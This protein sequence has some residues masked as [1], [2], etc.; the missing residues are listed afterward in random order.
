M[1]LRPFNSI[2][3]Y[4]VGNDPQVNVIY[5]NGD[6]SAV[7]LNVSALSNLG[8]IGNIT[9]TGGS[10][11]QAIVT[12]GNGVLSFSTIESESNRAAPMPY[13]IPTGESY[14]VNENFQGLYSYPITIDGTLEV[15]GILIELGTPIDA[16]DNQIFFSVNDV[17]TGNAGFTF[18]Q[19]SG[20]LAVP[21]NIEV[22]GNILPFTNV[23]YSLGSNSKRWNNLYLSGNTIVLGDSLITSDS[24][25]LILQNAD[26]GEFVISGTSLADTSLIA[27]GNSSIAIAANSNV[28]FTING[29]SNV[30]VIGETLT[31]FVSNV[32]V[33][34]IKT[35]NY[36][37]ANGNPLDLGGN[38]GGSNTQI[39]FN[40]QGEFDASANLTFDSSTNVLTLSGNLLANNI[41]G[42]NIVTA[43]YLVSSEG[44]VSI[45][46]GV[47][48]VINANAGIFSSTIENINLGLAANITMGS[49]SGLIT[50]RGNFQSNNISTAGTV[51]AEF[52]KVSDLYSKRAPISVSTNTVVDVFPASSYRSAKYTIKASNDL[53]YQA[54]EVLLVH[55]NI[56]SIITVYGSLSTTG[57]DIVTMTTSLNGSNVEL[58][59]TGLGSNTVVN[60]MG[61][62]VP[63]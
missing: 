4:T 31:S 37:Y 6:V 28:S 61:T 25:G 11:G 22:K 48:A 20:N 51:D 5:G 12:D 54:L 29:N 50:A 33:S 15:D 63:D 23:T 17:P 27:N 44:C 39:Q 42:G 45:N 19:A 14:I 35:D 21:G 34:G 60:L 53:G 47:I 36:Y 55:D 40:N 41:N 38:P 13:N 26:G 56:N 49:N 46:G 18:D 57:N 59:A 32:S 30:V 10:N 43:N 58:L 3:G 62:Y 8:P 1:A 2:E 9:I 52:V 24:S 16:T 7:N